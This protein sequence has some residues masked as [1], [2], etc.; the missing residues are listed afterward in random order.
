MAFIDTARIV[1]GRVC[2]M[3]WR[4]SAYPVHQPLQQ[5]VAH[6]L[7][8]ATQAGNIDCP[9]I[10]LSHAAVMVY[11]CGPSGQEIL[12]DSGSRQVPR[13]PAQISLAFSSIHKQC[14]VI[15]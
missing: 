3:V 11:C 14:H 12:I 7:L 6:L 1:S 9:I 15:R 10:W 4:P 8:E 2:V 5:C 13:R